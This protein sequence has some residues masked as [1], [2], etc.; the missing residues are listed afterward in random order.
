MNS[1][2]NSPNISAS[3]AGTTPGEMIVAAR[4]AKSISQA[5]LA[6]RLRLDTKV[7]RHLE[8]DDF[9]QLPGATFVKGYLRSIAK[10]L[11]LNADTLID[12]YYSVAKETQDPSLAD[13][14]S[15]PP[16]QA[17]SNSLLVK[18][19]SYG[20]AIASLLLIIFWWQ[21]NSKPTNINVSDLQSEE[22]VVSA[23]TPLSYEF[24][25]ITHAD[26]PIYRANNSGD[27]KLFAR[28]SEFDN[29]SNRNADEHST[30]SER[31][32]PTGSGLTLSLTTS[33]ESWVEINDSDGERLYFGMA[34]ARVPISISSDKPISLLI[35]NT[36][37]VDLQINEKKIDL[38]PLSIDGVARF[39][40]P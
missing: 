1:R 14:E 9:E 22:I 13:F 39:N 29:E 11:D 26:T 25:Q 16:P 37:T 33:A 24:E 34:N 20:L 35:G 7:V 38:A 10:E 32:A 4:E 19:G 27:E 3:I 18:V 31:L 12:S 6:Q 15:R 40:Y 36:P 23:S 8:V 5:D 21:S 28:D 2:A 30:E 17:S